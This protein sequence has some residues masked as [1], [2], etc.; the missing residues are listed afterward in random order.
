MSSAITLRNVFKTTAFRIS[1][2]YI[3]IFSLF[4]FFLIGY[5]V[6]SSTRLLTERLVEDMVTESQALLNFYNRSGIRR[7]ALAV[8]SRSRSPGAGVYLLT[9]PTGRYIAGNILDIPPRIFER[10]PDQYRPPV[11]YT[12]VPTNIT[13]FRELESEQHAGIF[14]VRTL[15]SGFK[16]VV[17]RDMGEMQRLP[18]IVL[19]AVVFSI[20]LLILLGIFSWFFITQRVLKRIDAVS[21]TGQQIMDGDFSKRLPLTGSGD[22]FDR[23]S[24]NLNA[25]LGRIEALVTGLKN[26]TDNVAHD[27]KTPIS[28]MRN[29]LDLAL[30]SVPDPDAQRDVLTSAIEECDKLIRIFDALLRIARVEAGA[31]AEELKLL[32]LSSII[33]DIAELYEAVA[34]ESGID[35]SVEISENISVNGNR[36]LLGQAVVNLVENALKY[37]AENRSDEGREPQVTIRLHSEK[38]HAIL[39]VCDN[40]PG[41]P[42]EQRSRVFERFVR[43]EESRTK[44]GSGLGLSL[45]RAVAHYLNGEIVLED[46]E[47]GLCAVLTLPLA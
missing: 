8:E 27:L 38:G 12:P 30:Q 22:E 4:A 16:L 7:F 46:N 3:V 29:R 2:I 39:R 23:L 28:R 1:A 36:E 45:V 26:V 42:Q 9:D 47:P 25:M 11:P 10:P 32:D 44:P 24:E 14:A 19:R 17:G 43:L 13:E 35:F 40:G 31:A 6:F 41:I 20:V 37:S 33:S 21:A 5:L 15:P 18:G 34:D